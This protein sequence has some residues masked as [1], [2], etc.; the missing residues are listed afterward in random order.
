M[1]LPYPIYRNES[2]GS[3]ADKINKLIQKNKK[4]IEKCII[5]DPYLRAMPKILDRNLSQPVWANLFSN[6]SA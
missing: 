1:T 5:F 2:T 6:P 3:T 4:A